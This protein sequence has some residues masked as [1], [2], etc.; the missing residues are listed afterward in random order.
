MAAELPWG[1]LKVV[2]MTGVDFMSSPG[3]FAIKSLL[4]ELFIVF[5]RRVHSMEDGDIVSC[6]LFYRFLK[7]IFSTFLLFYS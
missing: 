7:L 3:Y 2:T 4:Q 6:C 5:D 1:S